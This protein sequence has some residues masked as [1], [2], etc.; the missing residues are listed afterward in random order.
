MPFSSLV[1][2][3]FFFSSC[4][5]LFLFF[6]LNQRYTLIHIR[7]CGRVRDNFFFIRPISGNKTTFFY[8]S[9][10]FV[11][12]QPSE[13]KLLSNLHSCTVQQEATIKIH[14]REIFAAS[15]AESL[16]LFL[17]RCIRVLGN[18]CKFSKSQNFR[19]IL[20]RAD[21]DPFVYCIYCVQ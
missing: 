9:N 12:N 2:L 20:A 4:F 14:L 10:R 15:R 7:L 8:V 5:F 18:F 1:S 6:V 21:P 17:V 19:D 3:A 11:S 13:V 16:Q